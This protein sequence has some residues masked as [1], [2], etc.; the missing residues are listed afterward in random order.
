M[1][2]N[3]DKTREAVGLINLLNLLHVLFEK[4][5]L[6]ITIE[7][8]FSSYTFTG[9]QISEDRGLSVSSLC[10]QQSFDSCLRIP[11]K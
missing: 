5:Q 9:W 3:I 7:F 2:L 10:T 1:W 4:T 6:L 11:R 8:F